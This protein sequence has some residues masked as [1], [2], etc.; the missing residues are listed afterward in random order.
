MINCLSPSYT[1]LFKTEI[2]RKYFTFAKKVFKWVSNSVNLKLLP[3]V[4]SEQWANDLITTDFV[5]RPAP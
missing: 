4:L 3:D 5:L 1:H 2:Q